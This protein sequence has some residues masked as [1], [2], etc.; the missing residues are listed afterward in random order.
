MF[1][2]SF[3]L[4]LRI[5]SKHHPSTFTLHNHGRSPQLT[6]YIQT[7]QAFRPRWNEENPSAD[8]P[9]SR[10]VPGI[11]RR[12]LRFAILLEQLYDTFLH[13][14][15]ATQTRGT[16]LQHHFDQPTWEYLLARFIKSSLNENLF[17][18]VPGG[19]P[20]P[21]SG[22]AGAI[23]HLEGENES[24]NDIGDGTILIDARNSCI[25]S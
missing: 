5:H 1:N 13:L 16:L 9:L 10:R 24:G 14:G 4:N 2:F 12:D 17:L 19:P 20:S 22:L 18:G 8:P 15:K 3:R 7:I 23:D 25:D 6:L 11:T 21:L